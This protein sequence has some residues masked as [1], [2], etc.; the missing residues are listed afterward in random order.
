MSSYAAKVSAAIILL[1]DSGG[2]SLQAIKKQLQATKTQYRFIN[3]AIKKGVS[4]GHLTK[5]GGKYKVKLDKAKTA[6]VERV[7]PKQVKEESTATSKKASS[8]KKRSSK[9]TS[10]KKASSKTQSKTSKK[11][12]STKLKLTSVEKAEQKRNKAEA[13][14][15]TKAEKALVKARKKALKT[16]R[17]PMITIK[18][19]GVSFKKAGI[20]KVVRKLGE[21]MVE[22]RFSAP[23]VV[24]LKREPN[25]PYDSNAVAVLI[26]K[27]PIGYIPRSMNRSIDLTGTY[28]VWALRFVAFYDVYT[29]TIALMPPSFD[30]PTKV[31]VT[32][33]QIYF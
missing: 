21:V 32:G 3:A 33:N 29:C 14:A 12:K 27:T 28:L 4:S 2:S 25:N 18:V 11:S 6:K 1:K 30:N 7:Q 15:K 16:S 22:D 24:T 5:H 26:N 10:S 13:K 8:S 9:K 19:V 17:R 23:H 20:K 31:T